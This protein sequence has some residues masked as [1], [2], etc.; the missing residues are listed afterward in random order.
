[1]ALP[2]EYGTVFFANTCS[3]L[4]FFDETTEMDDW[5]VNLRR[6]PC[7]CVSCHSEY[8]AQRSKER[9]FFCH[10]ADFHPF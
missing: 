1:M 5:Q 3:G 6:S 8:A 2:I 9:A 10:C 7:C 4:L